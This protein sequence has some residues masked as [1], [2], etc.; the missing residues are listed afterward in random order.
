MSFD[1][2]DANS[3]L[4]EVRTKKIPIDVVFQIK[5]RHLEGVTAEMLNTS[6][7][8]ARSSLHPRH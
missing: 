7:Q 3:C 4:F 1:I 8:S 5:C 6:Q 2:E